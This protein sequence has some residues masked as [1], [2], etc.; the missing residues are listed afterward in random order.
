MTLNVTIIATKLKKT[1]ILTNIAAE[2]GLPDIARF[3]SEFNIPY[4][5]SSKSLFMFKSLVNIAFILLIP[6][7]AVH[8][9]Y[10]RTSVNLH[11]SSIVEY[12]VKAAC[13]HCRSTFGQKFSSL[14]YQ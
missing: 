12:A 4:V 1:I 9:H 10:T 13:T 3:S 8:S 14:C 5:T 2:L 11:V 7:T 6:N